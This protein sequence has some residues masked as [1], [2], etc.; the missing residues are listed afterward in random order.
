MHQK[1]SNL[2]FIIWKTDPGN[3]LVIEAEPL[4][5]YE[6]LYVSVVVATGGVARVDQDCVQLVHEWP[7]L[8]TASPV[9][10]IVVVHFGNNCSGSVLE[11][12]IDQLLSV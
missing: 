4:A 2:R 3:I 6:V 9:D 11:H 12:V 7:L 10:F 8:D 5:G 1:I